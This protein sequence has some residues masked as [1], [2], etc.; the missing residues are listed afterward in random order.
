MSMRPVPES[1]EEFC[2]YWDR[3]CSDELEINRATLDI[4]SIRIPKPWFVLM[5]TPI[6]DQIF[7]PMVGGPALDRGRACSTRRCGRRRVCAGPRVTRCFF[8]YS[9]S[10]SRW[11][12]SLCPTRSGCTLVPFPPIAAHPVALRRRAVGR[13]TRVHGAA[14]RPQRPAHALRP[15]TQEPARSRRLACAHDV[16]ARGPTP[17]AWTRHGS[18]ARSHARMV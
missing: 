1:W 14:A 15:A 12:S 7:K 11:R 18:L 2:E 13:G 6:W 17:G 8:D 3:V 9:A 16:L 10:W 5:P 4:F